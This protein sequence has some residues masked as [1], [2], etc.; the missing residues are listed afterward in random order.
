MRKPPKHHIAT[1]LASWC[2]Q[3]IQYMRWV[4]SVSG[5]NA[6]DKKRIVK[7]IIHN[8]TKPVDEPEEMPQLE[9]RPYYCLVYC[10]WYENGQTVQWSVMI[11]K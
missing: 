1:Y 2:A 9:V 3:Y 10:S 8:Y 6:A 7:E 5:Y 4:G 11:D